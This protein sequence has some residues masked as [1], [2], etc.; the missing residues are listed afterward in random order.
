MIDEEKLKKAKVQARTFGFSN[1]PKQRRLQNHFLLF[2]HND[3]DLEVVVEINEDREI[4]D[5]N[6]EK[7]FVHVQTCH[8][9]N[10]NPK[11]AYRFSSVLSNAA[12]LATML[13]TAIH[14]R[15][16]HGTLL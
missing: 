9:L 5:P 8:E 13:D 7:L 10:L 15:D 16:E 11:E 4:I 6:T 12:L 2:I 3:V 1:K 14:A